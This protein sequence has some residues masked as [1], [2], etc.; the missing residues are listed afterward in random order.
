MSDLRICLASITAS[1]TASPHAPFGDFAEPKQF[2]ATQAAL[3]QH[4]AFSPK[5]HMS[6]PRFST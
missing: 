5:R 2:T 4:L 1:S 3:P 6:G